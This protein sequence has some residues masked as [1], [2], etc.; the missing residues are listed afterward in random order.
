[1]NDELRKLLEELAP[2]LS[3][4]GALLTPEDIL[5]KI[6]SLKNM[7]L[8]T[9]YMGNL[10]DQ[11]QAEIRDRV[12]TE[13]NV[14]DPDPVV[15][16]ATGKPLIEDEAPT[17]PV[18]PVTGQEVKPTVQEN[19]TRA[20]EIHEDDNLDDTEKIELAE[21]EGVDELLAGLMAGADPQ[22]EYQYGEMGGDFY[23]EFREEYLLIHD[24][25]LNNNEI[26]NLLNFNDAEASGIANMINAGNP[27]EYSVIRGDD[28]EPI[29]SF[30]HREWAVITSAAGVDSSQL[31][32]VVNQAHKQGFTGNEWRLITAG[33]VM[34]G[35]FRSRWQGREGTPAVPAGR[36]RQHRRR[37]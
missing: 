21:E 27:M 22:L 20:R 12:F 35:A 11:V 36:S 1:M 33:M 32:Q 4:E 2:L 30:T 24:V 10:E 8:K 16:P 26:N 31:G 14:E 13:Y 28:G 9:T 5:E 25:E 29:R 6:P 3:D 15:N 18:D 34:N 17:G 7:D 19:E 37:Q 23:D